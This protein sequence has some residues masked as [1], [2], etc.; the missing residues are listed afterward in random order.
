MST[1][2]GQGQGSRLR[3]Q[4]DR[5]A[6]ARLPV[7][8]D[9]LE[10][11]VRACPCRSRRNYRAFYRQ[12]AYELYNPTGNGESGGDQR[13]AHPAVR[14]GGAPDQSPPGML[15]TRPAGRGGEPAIRIRTCCGRRP[16]CCGRRRWPC[17]RRWPASG[18]CGS[19]D[20]SI[21]A[22]SCNARPMT[23][24]A[25]CFGSVRALLCPWMK[26]TSHFE[27]INSATNKIP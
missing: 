22:R 16:G 9:E 2:P 24:P 11:R 12:L 21:A 13:Q 18:H 17:C 25:V 14:S 27:G 7:T 15:V 10:A 8:G 23:V 19:W 4:Q 6:V 26:R 1:S 5:L 20:P 3:G